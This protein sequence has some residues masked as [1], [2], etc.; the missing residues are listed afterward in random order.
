MIAIITCACGGAEEMARSILR[1]ADYKDW[2]KMPIAKGK[3][4]SKYVMDSLRGKYQNDDNFKA[5]DGYYPNRSS[6][7]VIIGYD[8]GVFKWADVARGKIKER[9][10]GELIVRD[11]S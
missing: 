9:L 11:F 3:D 4:Q 10:D 6:Y 2:L 7:I 5:L 8:K 1:Q